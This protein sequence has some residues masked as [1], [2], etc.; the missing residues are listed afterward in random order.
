MTDWKTATTQMAGRLRRNSLGGSLVALL[1]L[2][3]AP[4]TAGANGFGAALGWLLLLAFCLVALAVAVHLL[5][6]AF[7]F[8]V[9]L[10]HDSEEAGLS[11]IDELLA[12]MGLRVRPV[13]AAPLSQRFSGCRR[14]ILLQRLT[15]T[16][17]IVLY[18]I[19]LLDAVNGGP[20]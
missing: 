4:L 5:F 20:Q 10:S 7:L 14:L 15:L 1:V 12:R 8:R 16:I 17:G 18:G 2:A 3:I 9:A 6:D 19:L 13:V 11:A